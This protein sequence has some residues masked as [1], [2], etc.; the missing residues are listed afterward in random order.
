MNAVIKISKM[1]KIGGY[2]KLQTTYFI[3]LYLIL[4]VDI[5]IQFYKI[6]Y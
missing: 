5:I 6:S 1:I 4:Y 3:I 2:I